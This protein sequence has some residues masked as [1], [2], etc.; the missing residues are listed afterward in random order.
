[1]TPEDPRDWKVIDH[2]MRMYLVAVLGPG[3]AKTGGGDESTGLE[4]MDGS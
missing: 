3:R 1:M 2:W 4:V